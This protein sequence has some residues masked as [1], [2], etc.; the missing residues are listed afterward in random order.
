MS[1]INEQNVFFTWFFLSV[2]ISFAI[3]RIEMCFACDYYSHTL[4]VIS[5]F[6]VL[7]C[8]FK[9]TIDYWHVLLKSRTLW[10]CFVFGH[11]QQ[12]Q[13]TENICVKG[14]GCKQNTI[15]RLMNGKF[16]EVESPKTFSINIDKRVFDS[17]FITH[18]L[19]SFN[20]I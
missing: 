16:E 15:N 8:D 13:Q 11:F 18:C 4:R 12:F 17:T 1:N 6:F 7:L 2:S 9:S 14:H 5:V 10:L 3:Y 19:E 20:T